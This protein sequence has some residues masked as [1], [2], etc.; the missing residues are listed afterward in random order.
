MQYYDSNVALLYFL[1]WGFQGII[2][3]F[4]PM[5]VVGHYFNPFRGVVSSLPFDRV[6][7]CIIDTDIYVWLASKQK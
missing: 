5:G 1:L 6:L 2:E 3:L 7:V 4:H